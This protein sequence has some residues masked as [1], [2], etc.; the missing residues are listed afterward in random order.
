MNFSVKNAKNFINT[1]LSEYSIPTLFEDDKAFGEFR[2][3][4]LF[5]SEQRAEDV[6][7]KFLK[8]F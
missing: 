3:K 1:L 5:E 8:F 6:I 4:Y 7:N 2:E